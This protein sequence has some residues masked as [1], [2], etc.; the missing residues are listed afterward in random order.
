MVDMIAYR[1]VVDLEF[2]V[3]TLAILFY[4]PTLA[5]LRAFMSVAD[6]GDETAGEAPLTIGHEEA[7]LADFRITHDDKFH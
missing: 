7:S 5:S 1:C 4:V 6:A 3:P 2:H